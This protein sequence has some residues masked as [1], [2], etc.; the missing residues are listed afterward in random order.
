MKDVT[1]EN[2]KDTI[3]DQKGLVL[4]DCYQPYCP[5]CFVLDKVLEKLQKMYPNIKM[6]QINV[7]KEKDIKDALQIQSVPYVLFFEHGHFLKSIYAPTRDDLVTFIDKWQN[8]KAHPSY[9]QP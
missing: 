9:S 1:L 4:V 6:C 7:V 3:I 5:P 8:R 2:F